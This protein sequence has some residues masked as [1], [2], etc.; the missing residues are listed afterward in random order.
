MPDG[1]WEKCEG[2]EEA[3]HEVRYDDNKGDLPGHKKSKDSST[4]HGKYTSTRTITE[5]F[6]DLEHEPV[7]D[8]T[9]AG[10]ICDKCD[11]HVDVYIPSKARTPGASHVK[12]DGHWG[13][14]TGSLYAKV[15][16][17]G[18]LL[19]RIEK[20][21]ILAGGVTAPD[22]APTWEKRKIDHIEDRP[23]VKW[24]EITTYDCEL[25]CQDSSLSMLDDYGWTK[26]ALVSMLDK[27]GYITGASSFKETEA[28]PGIESY[29]PAG[30]VF[31][32]AAQLIPKLTGIITKLKSPKYE[33]Q[34][35]GQKV[36]LVVTDKTPEGATKEVGRLE[37]EYCDGAKLLLTKGWKSG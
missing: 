30:T 20:H 5:T 3:T 11:A 10:H 14:Q 29:T 13:Y 22:G 36:L 17:S 18:I 26:V 9:D 27:A 34:H 33:F 37:M 32:D 1:N 4:T 16:V 12:S 2:S 21:T 35:H 15:R 7:G 6:S 31:I 24:G 19:R 8:P 23:Y 28:Y 25:N